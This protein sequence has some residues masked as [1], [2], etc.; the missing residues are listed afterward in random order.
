VPTGGEGTGFRLAVNDDATDDQIGIIEGHSIRM[1][2]RMAKLAALVNGAGGFRR[3]M[4]GIPQGQ[5]N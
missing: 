1:C 3:Y 2:Q 4:T 5:E